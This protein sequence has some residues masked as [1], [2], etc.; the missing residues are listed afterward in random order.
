M[1]PGNP[2]PAMEAAPCQED[3]FPVPPHL[4]LERPE[5]PEADEKGALPLCPR[6]FRPCWA[7]KEGAVDICFCDRGTT[8]EAS[9]RSAEKADEDPALTGPA[10]DFR[11]IFSECKVRWTRASFEAERILARAES[12]KAKGRDQQMREGQ[13]NV[14][15]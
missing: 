2:P 14:N 15:G 7:E 4:P 8:G 11:G 5:P 13:H 12:R 3:F 10:E 9:P 1:P 6:F